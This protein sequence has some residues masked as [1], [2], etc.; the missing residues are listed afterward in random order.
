MSIKSANV[1]IS[2]FF[3]K[4]S[5]DEM[6]GEMTDDDFI[7]Y[8]METFYDDIHSFIKYGEL[9]QYIWVETSDDGL[10]EERQLMLE[11]DTQQ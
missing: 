11:F 1:G 7:E 5:A 3:D 4:R 6:L 9:S 8:A 10:D 2:F